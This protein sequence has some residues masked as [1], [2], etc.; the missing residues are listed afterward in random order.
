MKELNSPSCVD[1]EIDYR[2]PSSY[3][4]S[5]GKEKYEKG[6]RIVGCENVP[7]RR[8]PHDVIQKSD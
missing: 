6:E 2:R 7:S 8:C 3:F 1:I 5:V 4:Y